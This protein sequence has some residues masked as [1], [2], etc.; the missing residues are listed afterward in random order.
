M[1]NHLSKATAF[2]L[3]FLMLS[4][5][6]LLTTAQNNAIS[7]RLLDTKTGLPAYTLNVVV[8]QTLVEYYAEKNR[9]I[10]SINEFSKFVTPYSVKP[11][12]DTLLKLYRNE[13]DFVNAALAIVHQMTYVETTLGKYPVQTLLDGRGDCDIFSFVAASIVSAGELKV[14]LF[15]FEE[16]KHMN[17]GVHLT[18][19]P[20][21][22][23]TGVYKFDFEG[24][25]YYIA[26]C[27]GGN[28]TTGWRVGECPENLKT[29]KAQILALSN[30]EEVAP[31]QVSAGFTELENSVLS[32]K[33][34][35]P[36][37]LE[38]N[39]VAIQGYLYPNKPN[40]NIT[41]YLGLS[42]QRWRVLGKTTTL[43]DGS[44]EYIWKSETPGVYGIRAS[45]AGDET[46][47]GT[48]S[49]T[50][51]VAI[52]PLFLSLLVVAA[53]AATVAGAVALL[54][55]RQAGQNKLEPKEPQPPAL[56]IP[57]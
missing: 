45:W 38:N 43:Q 14:V 2:L 50:T 40:E 41:I 26:E 4:S 23:R 39:F 36:F 32:L 56:E 46:Y 21:D 18:N 10:H 57:P 17:I 20:E 12:S 33:V 13:E 8:P 7:F 6:A 28:W 27:T 9:A 34:K 44:F 5:L 29:A 42:G 24:L 1:K 11:I 49:N 22:A 30:A 37:T 48:T 54:A 25:P 15:Y 19:P 52:F 31:G 16:K 53:I 3:M 47:A 55:S 35:P 51:D